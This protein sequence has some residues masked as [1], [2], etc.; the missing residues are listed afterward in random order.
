MG[1]QIKKTIEHKWVVK[2]VNIG[3][4]QVANQ[5]KKRGG[6][7]L[8]N[9]RGAQREREKKKKEKKKKTQQEQNKIMEVQR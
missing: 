3:V 8:A 2:L 4:R 7:M 1:V 9:N 6:V 5:S